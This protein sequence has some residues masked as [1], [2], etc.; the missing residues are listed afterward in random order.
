MSWRIPTVLAAAIAA[1]LVP[2][3]PTAVA[4]SEGRTA[5]VCGPYGEI[6]AGFSREFD[7]VPVVSAMTD[8]GYAMEVLASPSGTWTIVIT[9]PGGPSCAIATGQEWETIKDEWMQTSHPPL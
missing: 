3:A 4:N 1:A 2:A 7:E 8:R 6:M 9:Q 5:K